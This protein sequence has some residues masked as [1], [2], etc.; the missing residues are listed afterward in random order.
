MNSNPAPEEERVRIGSLAISNL[1]WEEAIGKVEEMIRVQE[2]DYAL[3]PN[4]DHVVLAER[5]PDLKRIY[6]E[7]PLVLADGMPLLWAAR[8]LGAPLKE[9]ISGSDFLDRFCRTAADRGYRLYFLGGLPGAAEL[10]AAIL[11]EKYP[12]LII[13]GIDSPPRGFERSEEGNLRVI[14]KIRAA[15]PDLIFVGLG[16]PKQEKWISANRRRHRVPVSFPVGAGFDF[17]SGKVRRAPLGM[18]RCGLEWL[19]RLIREPLRLGKRYLVRDLAFFPI[20]VKQKFFEGR[21]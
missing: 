5:D 9:K 15:R 21:T 11:S 3:T 1:T 17:I 7:C 12:G 4:V 18:R 2:P 8:F 6:A 20:I 14:G 19:W 13:A 16:T 10:S